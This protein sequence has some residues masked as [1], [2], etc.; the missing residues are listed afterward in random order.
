MFHNHIKR[1]L[2]ID[3]SLD[4]VTDEIYVYENRQKDIASSITSVVTAEVIYENILARLKENHAKNKEEL[5]WRRVLVTDLKSEMRKIIRSM[6]NMIGQLD[7][8]KE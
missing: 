8:D 6:D 1:L 4:K 7:D 2:E 5:A 3:Q